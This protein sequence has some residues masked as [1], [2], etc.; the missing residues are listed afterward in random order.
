MNFKKELFSTGDL[1]DE[2]DKPLYQS[3]VGSLRW[4]MIGTRPELL[5]L[6]KFPSL[7][8]S[9]LESISLLKE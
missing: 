7:S 5:L 9:P 4:A 3:L 8:R 1:I 6:E 2:S